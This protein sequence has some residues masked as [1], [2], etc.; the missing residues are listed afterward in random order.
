MSTLI[1]SYNI[2]MRLGH[3]GY[4]FTYLIDRLG[5]LF[6]AESHWWHCEKWKIHRSKYTKTYIEI[7]QEHRNLS[8]SGQLR[9]QRPWEKQ[10]IIHIAMK[11]RRCITLD[12]QGREH[13]LALPLFAS[14]TVKL[15]PWA[16]VMIRSAAAVSAAAREE[17]FLLSVSVLSLRLSWGTFVFFIS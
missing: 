15:T 7:F 16:N 5:S 2:V 11:W 6:E 3:I 10:E 9:H 1:F 17:Y 4:L 8:A 13:A 12:W 14:Q